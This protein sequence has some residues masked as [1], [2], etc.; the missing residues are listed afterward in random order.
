MKEL[1]FAVVTFIQADTSAI[2]RP[3][4]ILAKP[5]FGSYEECFSYVQL[6]NLDIYKVAIESY[7]YKLKPES[8]YCLQREAVEDIFKYNYESKQDGKTSI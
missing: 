4:Y 1:F 3:L 8:I 6:K 5:N 2:D 7:N